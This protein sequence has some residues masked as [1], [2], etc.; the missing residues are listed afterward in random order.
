[1]LKYTHAQ[2]A[3]DQKKQAVAL[4]ASLHFSNTQTDNEFF[5]SNTPHKVSK[6]YTA[7]YFL[8]SVRLRV[9]SH[10]FRSLSMVRW[11]F[12]PCV[13]TPNDLRPF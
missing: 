12:A 5:K 7:I 9:F 6:Y 1:M 2:R 11:I 13:N 4:H 3:F 8:I 10:F